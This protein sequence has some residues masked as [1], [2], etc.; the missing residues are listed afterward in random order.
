M[1]QFQKNPAYASILTPLIL[2]IK[3]LVAANSEMK[4]EF[5]VNIEALSGLL[6]AVT[7]TF[8]H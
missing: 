7:N 5:S 2:A 4:Q 8:D 3:S 1:I 6:N